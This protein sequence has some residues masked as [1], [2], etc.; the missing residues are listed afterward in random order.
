MTYPHAHSRSSLLLPS[1]NKPYKQSTI[2]GLLNYKYCFLLHPSNPHGPITMTDHISTDNSFS[3]CNDF[4][5]HLY[6]STKWWHRRGGQARNLQLWDHTHIH[7][8]KPTRMLARTIQGIKWLSLGKT[9]KEFST[10]RSCVQPLHPSLDCAIAGALSPFREGRVS[11]F[12]NR[13][14]PVSPA[15]LCSVC[16]YKLLRG[17]FDVAYL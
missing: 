17:H 8:Q 6:L 4:H 9:G 3:L 11:L 1:V 2:D 10:N 7:T 13:F 16:E 5:S 12:I 15:R 14:V